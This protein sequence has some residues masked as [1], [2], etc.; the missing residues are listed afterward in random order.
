MLKLK[1]GIVTRT[2][3]G[4]GTYIY[5]S[6]LSETL[7]IPLDNRLFFEALLEGVIDTSSLIELLKNDYDCSADEALSAV[8]NTIDSLQKRALIES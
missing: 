3:L 5:D 1:P 7:F 6:K 8:D 2:N 4:H